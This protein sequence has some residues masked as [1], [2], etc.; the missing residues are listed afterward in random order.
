MPISTEKKFVPFQLLIVKGFFGGAGQDRIPGGQ[1]L[2]EKLGI[3]R[4]MHEKT[5]VA[6]TLS[7]TAACRWKKTF[8]AR[9]HK[10]RWHWAGRAGHAPGRGL[11][12][13]KQ[14]G[15]YRSGT[16]GKFPQGRQ[17]LPS[18]HF[19]RLIGVIVVNNSLPIFVLQFFHNHLFSFLLVLRHD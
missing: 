10:P 6:G 9:R 4:M 5:G 11:F 14:G 15:R 17:G 3:S 7:G 1:T 12:R 2:T 8:S 13:S 18:A 16:N 19:F